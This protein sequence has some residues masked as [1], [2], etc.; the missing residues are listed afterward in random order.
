MKVLVAGN[1]LLNIIT[2]R[3]PQAARFEVTDWDGETR[4]AQYSQFEVAGP[5]DKYRLSID[6]YNGTA[7]KYVCLRT[8]TD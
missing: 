5:E 7:G 8:S 6:G 2:E 3:E 1:K 4:Y